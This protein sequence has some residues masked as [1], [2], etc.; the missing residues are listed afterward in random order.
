MKDTMRFLIMMIYAGL[1]LSTSYAEDKKPSPIKTVPPSKPNPPQKK[2]GMAVQTSSSKQPPK[3]LDLQGTKHDG[4]FRLIFKWPENLDYSAHLENNLLHMAFH[5]SAL[6][7]WNKAR[8]TFPS[9]YQIKS[10]RE[11]KGIYK[12]TLALGEKSYL[13]HHRDGNK[14]FVDLHAQEI[15]PGKRLGK[16]PKSIPS[17]VQKTILKAVNKEINTHVEPVEVE[18]GRKKHHVSLTFDWTKPV[19]AAVARRGDLLWIMFDQPS[20]PDLSKV[21]QSGKD[22]V[23]SITPYNNGRMTVLRLKIPFNVHADVSKEKCHWTINL[24]DHNT[25]PVNRSAP[26]IMS[27]PNQ[28]FKFH[29]PIL[30]AKHNFPFTDPEVGDTI[31]FIP[32]TELGHG[33]PLP[34]QNIDFEILPSVQGAAIIPLRSKL[35]FNF[36]LKFLEID[37]PKGLMLSSNGDRA[38]Q[39]RNAVDRKLFDFQAW[40]R[41]DNTLT[42]KRQ[43]MQRAVIDAPKHKKNKARL[44]LAAFLVARAQ[45]NEAMGTLKYIRELT[46]SLEKDPGFLSLRGAAYYLTGYYDLSEADFSAKELVDEPEAKIWLGM[47][48]AKKQSW[49]KSYQQLRLG[50]L[51][52]ARYP[53]TL[54]PRF[55]FLAAETAYQVGALKDAQKFLDALDQKSLTLEEAERYQ[56]QKSKIFYKDERLDKALKIW[57]DLIKDGRDQKSKVEATYL[58]AHALMDKNKITTIEAIKLLETVRYSWRGDDLEL[59][60]LHT[61]SQLYYKAG[62]H[63]EWLSLLRSVVQKF[64]NHPNIADYKKELDSAVELIF[65]NSLQQ[66]ISPI[67]MLGLY[68]D[69]RNLIPKDEK[70]ERM[71]LALINKLIQVDLL[72]EAS[73]VLKYQV[74]IEKDQT[75]QVALATK[76]ATLQFL[77]RRPQKTIKTLNSYKNEQNLDESIR[78]KRTHLKA[79]ALSTLNKQNQAL[80]LLAG[81]QSKA[82]LQ[83]KAEIYWA[84][85]EW[86]KVADELAKIE[87]KVVVQ[88]DKLRSPK[89]IKEHAQRILDCCIALSLAGK[90]EA[91]KNLAETKAQFVKNTPYEATFNMI[92]FPKGKGIPLEQEAIR[93]RMTQIGQ[94]EEFVS[95]YRKKLESDSLDA[96]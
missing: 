46:P 11:D 67:V 37:H 25:V 16:T 79:R 18:V 3:S 86:E 84:Q 7:E 53:D 48:A 6:V 2:A 85:K 95:T 51:I 71:M 73:K 38:R 12:I 36:N 76:L 35:Q 60:I 44:D 34:S 83:V 27:V 90:K 23:E 92:V 42:I 14:V 63:K 89:E 33:Y 82:G 69:F 1:F 58:K 31:Q 47:I 22:F 57:D 50:R 54:R 4:F 56:L 17:K 29:Y 28:R 61:L 15:P 81:D 32:T 96:L 30:G 55:I 94:F 64:P 66:P 24:Y 39:K 72:M 78:L 9:T 80:A 49:T 20:K 62:H 68:R 10:V 91:L 77:D 88:E 21:M 43:Q 26:Y 8:S 75:K 45:G 87:A 74:R 65:T 13:D 59:H 93:E 52:V 41:F 70:G 19:G 40:G 5:G